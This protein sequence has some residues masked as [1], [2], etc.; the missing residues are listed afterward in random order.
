MNTKNKYHLISVMVIYYPAILSKYIHIIGDE[1]KSN[2][3][4]PGLYENEVSVQL[5]I[6]V[7][8]SF[9]HSTSTLILPLIILCS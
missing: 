8:P 9:N 5:K 4:E 2:I 3:T 6:C 1:Y 7:T